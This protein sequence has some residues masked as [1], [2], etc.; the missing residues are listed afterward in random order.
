MRTE[1]FTDNLSIVDN[2]S[3]VGYQWLKSKHKGMIIEVGL[4]SY[5]G[6]GIDLSSKG[7]WVRRSK[8]EYC[9][10]A[11]SRNGEGGARIFKFDTIQEMYLWLGNPN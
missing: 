9:D 8:Q 3:I 2:K 10:R 4:D 1:I 5:I 6:I 7:K 11:L